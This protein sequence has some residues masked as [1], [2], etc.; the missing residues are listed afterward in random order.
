MAIED[1]VKDVQR[2]VVNQLGV[3]NGLNNSIADGQVTPAKMSTGCPT[4]ESNGAVL[5]SGDRIEINYG[6]VGDDDAYID[7]HSSSASF[8]NFD[9]RIYKHTGE[10][11]NFQLE[12]EG[13]GN[14]V[15]YQNNEV[16]FLT[17][18]G[19]DGYTTS[20]KT[21]LL[22]FILKFPK[23]NTDAHTKGVNLIMDEYMRPNPTIKT[24]NYFNSVLNQQKMKEY[25][26]IDVLYQPPFHPAPRCQR[27]SR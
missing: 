12:N 5:T 3:A 24:L 6:L 20:G 19:N 22:I 7:F 23:S 1:E 25:Q 4:W 21:N 13:T 17:T 27:R 18:D 16:K 26:A 11:S 8:P 14:T 15:I 2:L 9:A 10:N